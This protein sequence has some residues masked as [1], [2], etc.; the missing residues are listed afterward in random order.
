MRWTG[1][2]ERDAQ[3]RLGNISNPASQEEGEHLSNLVWEAR[4]RDQME[5][6]GV[7]PWSGRFQRDDQEAGR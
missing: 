4:E 3:H 1:P 2:R 7:D 6:Q 5:R